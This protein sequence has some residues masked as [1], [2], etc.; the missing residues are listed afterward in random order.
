MDDNFD[1]KLKEMAR[2]SNVKE[3]W[4]IKDL[5]KS[6]YERSNNINKFLK[7]K[8]VIIAAGILIFCITSFGIYTS[9]KGEEINIINK[10]LDYF[11]KNNKIDTGYEGNT[12]DENYSANEDKYN[13]SI[14]D[15]YFDGGK[16]EFFYKI[17]SSE[18]LD[19]S[20]TYYLNTTLKVN[21]D[22]EATGGLEEK[23]FIDDY[24]YYGMISYGINSN[25]SEI[26]P[27]ILDGT[28]NIN[29]IDIYKKNSSDS[30]TIKIN[31]EPLKINL[32]SKNINKKEIPINK[33]IS[34]NGL[35]EE[36]DKLIKSPTGISIDTIKSNTANQNNSIYFRTYLWDSKKGVLDFKDK[37]NDTTDKG[38]LIREEYENPSKDGELSIIYFV[39][40]SGAIGN[41]ED[42][43]VTYKLEE[44]SKLDLGNLGEIHVESILDSDNKTAITLRTTGYISVDNIQ[45]LNGDERY[46]ATEV[47]DKEVY[48]E[49]DM[50]A[51]YVFPKLDK[52]AGIYIKLY[53]PKLLQLLSSETIRVDLSNFK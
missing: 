51:K 50:K 27:E 32:D 35:E 26:W 37:I 13:V 15:L 41:G 19:K 8:K 49:L 11:I 20:S 18:M 3:P 46:L 25:S 4:D 17:K 12:I 53:H 23:E 1:K 24:T 14:E 36:I 7:Y 34:Y 10:V 22:I 16:L 48:G 44:G 40:E 42:S 9:A 28:I 52:E 21:V 30:E 33:I 29:S 5:I 2:S 45:V 47:N 31:T 39:S 38:I 6:S 43:S